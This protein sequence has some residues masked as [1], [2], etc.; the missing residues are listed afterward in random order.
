MIDTVT[1]IGKR[2]GM[3]MDGEET[4]TINISRQSSLREIMTDYTQLE[5]VEY[6]NYLG[7]I[8]TNDGKCAREIRS[9]IALQKRG[10]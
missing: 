9:R 6:L 3:T 7:S 10:K 5:N 4:N 2:Y 1:E 8:K